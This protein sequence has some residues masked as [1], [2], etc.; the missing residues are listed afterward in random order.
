[1]VIP[2]G[3]GLDV[4]DPATDRVTRLPATTYDAR[5]FRTVTPVGEL[6]VLV[7]GGYNDAITPTDEAVVITI[8]PAVGS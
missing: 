8:P 3:D 5:S 4:F 7:A 2:T 1:V 6:R